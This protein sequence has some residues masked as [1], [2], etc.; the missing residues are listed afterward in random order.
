M[1]HPDTA[2]LK[3]AN[4]CGAEAERL[5]D[6]EC[7]PP[8]VWQ[9]IFGIV[10][11]ASDA[12][13]RRDMF[14]V[15]AVCRDWRRTAFY[16]F[17]QQQW[18][19]PSDFIHPLQLLQLSG[20]SVPGHLLQCFV[21]REKMP[22]FGVG[23][24]RFS[25]FLGN[26]ADEQGFACKFLLAAHQT[27]RRHITLHLDRKCQGPAIARLRCSLLQMAYCAT[28]TAACPLPFVEER[29]QPL[30]A[31]PSV[32]AR[33]LSMSLVS[34]STSG[35]PPAVREVRLPPVLAR[36]S[37][38]LRLKGFMR[39]RKMHITL[40]H[41]VELSCFEVDSAAAVRRLSGLSDSCPL[42]PSLLPVASLAA[43][44]GDALLP[45]VSSGSFAALK[46]TASGP[47]RTLMKSVRRG[48]RLSG[49]SVMAAA[50]TVPP[51]S[52]D[53]QIDAVIES[54]RDSQAPSPAE[55]QESA[56][57]ASATSDNGNAGGGNISGNRLGTSHSEQL[58]MELCNKVPH[59]NHEIRCHCLNFRGR[60][61]V[62]SIKNYQLTAKDPAMTAALIAAA[63]AAPRSPHSRRGRS[64]RTVVM[65]FGKVSDS[66]Y[67]LD[68]NPTMLSGLQA[69][70]IALT[71]FDSKLIF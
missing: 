34:C 9:K 15:T 48:L 17:F 43:A 44:G 69:F 54:W 18:Q 64:S 13:A 42:P 29:A 66:S 28:T 59:W 51:S 24:V 19:A 8:H 63:E 53:A 27:T 36:C 22:C 21:R 37:Y 1:A 68:Y 16:Q 56:T 65:Q 61:K 49:A 50:A 23:S 35:P 60:V 12:S 25:F 47:A 71:N 4:R 58:P 6:V 32:L 67:I 40:P 55:G 31:P 20:R 11:D 33:I 10:Q 26:S 62:A 46:R 7:L 70:C 3:A 38:A 57:S 41:P 5:R 45:A 52:L 14:A 2:A 39:P 30:P